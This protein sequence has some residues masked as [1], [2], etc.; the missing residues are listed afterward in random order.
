MYMSGFAELK[1]KTEAELEKDWTMYT[2]NGWIGINKTTGKK[3]KR[4]TYYAL[5]TQL[6]IEE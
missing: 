1:V 4:G 2:C 6:S 5:L 3:I